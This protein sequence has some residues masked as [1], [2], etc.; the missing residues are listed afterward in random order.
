MLRSIGPAIFQAMPHDLQLRVAT[1]EEIEDAVAFGLRFHGR[2]RV[3]QGD[4]FMAQ[5]A[6]ER[7]VKHLEQSGLCAV[8]S[9]DCR[10]FLGLGTGVI[11]SERRRVSR[12]LFVG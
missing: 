7:L 12:I 2:K 9:R 6:A 1:A 11:G 5:I 8:W 10:R 4:E 3:H